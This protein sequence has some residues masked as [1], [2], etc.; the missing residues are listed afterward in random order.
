[1]ITDGHFVLDPHRQAALGRQD[2][3]CMYPTCHEVETVNVNH[4]CVVLLSFL[5]ILLLLSAHAHLLDLHVQRLDLTANR[6]AT[7]NELENLISLPSLQ[8]LVLVSNPVAARSATFTKTFSNVSS[9]AAFI[10]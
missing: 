8:Q 9:N 3:S 6:I 2:L 7:V 4:Y 10:I 5:S 1:M